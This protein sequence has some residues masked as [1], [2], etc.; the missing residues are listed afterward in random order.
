MLSNLIKIFSAW[1]RSDRQTG[2]YQCVAGFDSLYLT[3]EPA[4]LTVAHL[5]RFPPAPA[6]SPIHVEVPVGIDTVASIHSVLS[7][8]SV[9]ISGLNSLADPKSI[10]QISPQ[11]VFSVSDPYRLDPNVAKVK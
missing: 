9:L 3:S 4:S 7:S 5:D 1:W 11:L 6:T 10:N 2:R 8:F